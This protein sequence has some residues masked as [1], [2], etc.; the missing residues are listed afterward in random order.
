M[1]TNM[2]TYEDKVVRDFMRHEA[3]NEDYAEGHVVI[4][5]WI[6]RCRAR[7]KMLRDFWFWPDWVA[8]DGSCVRKGSIEMSV[9]RQWFDGVWD[10][11]PSMGGMSYSY[12]GDGTCLGMG[13][14]RYWEWK[15]RA[16]IP[17]QKCGYLVEWP[18]E[19]RHDLARGII[20][21]R[22]HCA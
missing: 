5:N 7:L 13:Q 9:R 11:D 21:A 18:V 10:Y 3:H 6:A 15:I 17:C 20:A 2:D 12:K 1:G 22:K 14:R 4:G 16:Y 19:S 8:E